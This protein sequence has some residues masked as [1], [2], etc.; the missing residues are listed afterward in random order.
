MV[1]GGAWEPQEPSRET[2][3]PRDVTKYST[4][5]SS[6]PTVW[7]GAEGLACALCPCPYTRSR[8]CTVIHSIARVCTKSRT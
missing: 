5:R 8:S 1:C 4:V 2:E 6:R 7:P 3:R